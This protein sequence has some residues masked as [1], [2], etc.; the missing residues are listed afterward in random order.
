MTAVLLVMHGFN[1]IN[2]KHK[3]MEGGGGEI[4]IPLESAVKG[5]GNVSLS[6]ATCSI[7]VVPSAGVGNTGIAGTTNK[8]VR[9]FHGKLP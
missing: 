1:W 6:G 4:K 7:R 9:R 8:I 5:V 2:L 3:K